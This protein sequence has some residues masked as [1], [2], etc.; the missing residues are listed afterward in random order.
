MHDYTSETLSKLKG[1]AQTEPV[2]EIH[3]MYDVCV[4][5][6]LLRVI[7]FNSGPETTPLTHFVHDF[8]KIVEDQL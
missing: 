6:S 5:A 4:R 2:E 7:Q 1:K 8:F 3:S